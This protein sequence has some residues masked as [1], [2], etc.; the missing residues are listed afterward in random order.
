[1]DAMIDLETLG[2]GP[3]AAIMQIGAALFETQV[4]RRVVSTVDDGFEV[5][6]SVASAL[7]HGRAHADQGTIEWWRKRPASNLSYVTSNGRP[8]PEALDQLAA[9]LKA[10]NVERVWG[11][12]AAF[13]IAILEHAYRAVGMEVPWSHR[14]VRDT[15]TVFWLAE[16][17]GWKRPNTGEPVHTG[18][19]DALAQAEE[20]LDALDRLRD[21]PF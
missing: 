14:D 19:M 4:N 8:L 5:N 18:L 1:M 16:Q 3:T 11:H 15:R 20:V 6:V 21:V 2:L 10:N 7:I 13:D 17:K 9:W 12:G